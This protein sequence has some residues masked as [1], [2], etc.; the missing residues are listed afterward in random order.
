MMTRNYK[1]MFIALAAPF[2]W[3]AVVLSKSAIRNYRGVCKATGRPMTALEKRQIFET[4]I[5][6]EIQK[7]NADPDR[8]KNSSDVSDLIK[9]HRPDGRNTRSDILNIDPIENF[10]SFKIYPEV[11]SYAKSPNGDFDSSDHFAA[12][13][14]PVP[15]DYKLTGYAYDL[16]FFRMVLK[17]T[18]LEGG[19]FVTDVDYRMWL[20][21][22]GKEVSLPEDYWWG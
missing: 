15:I 22:C 10:D 8:A 19:Y 1:L 9:R 2:F 3:G 17:V 5:R 21:S 6:S 7:F 16:A 12:D 18:T 13:Y 14:D 4:R 20:D 11:P